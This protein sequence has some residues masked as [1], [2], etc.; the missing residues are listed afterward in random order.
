[1]PKNAVF[2]MKVESDLRDEFMMA[3]SQ[4]HRPAS[5]VLREL[6]RTFIDAQ[7]KEQT[8][9]EFLEEKIRKARLS[10]KEGRVRSNQEVSSDFIERRAA[11]MGDK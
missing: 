1:M 11:L 6:M 5:Q 7:K 4:V 2:T 3:A 9:D 10:V 8:Y